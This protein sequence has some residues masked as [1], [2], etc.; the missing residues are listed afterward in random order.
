MFFNKY[1]VQ[2]L[3]P[4]LYDAL[5]KCLN[6]EKEIKRLIQWNICCVKLLD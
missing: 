5:E 2:E 4:V 1:D 6:R 3:C